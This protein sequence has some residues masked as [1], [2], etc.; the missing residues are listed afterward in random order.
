VTIAI[1]CVLMFY[2]ET[3]LWMVWMNDMAVKSSVN[4][5]IKWATLRQQ[6]GSWHAYNKRAC[7]KILSRRNW[8]F[9]DE[10]IDQMTVCETMTV[11]ESRDESRRH[12]TWE[13]HTHAR[14]REDAYYKLQWHYHVC[15]EIS[16][17]VT[18]SLTWNSS[19]WERL[20]HNLTRFPYKWCL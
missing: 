16:E 20:I 19:C 7:P 13:T 5:S 12:G 8:E 9:T 2:N 3:C 4:N 18:D 15:L 14:A 11:R 6:S 10:E 1:C 17:H